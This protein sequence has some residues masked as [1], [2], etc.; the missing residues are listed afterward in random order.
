MSDPTT[1][2]AAGSRVDGQPGEAS[3]WNDDLDPHLRPDLARSALLTIDVQVD[4]L[5]GGAL[6]VPGTSE[7]LPAMAGLV[8]AYRAAGLPVVHV[9]RL[10]QGEDVDLPRRTAIAAGAEI[11]RPGT[12]G[13]QLAPALRADPGVELDHDLLLSGGPQMVGAREAILFKPRWSAFYRTRLAELLQQW[14]CT[15]VVVAGCNYPNCPRASLYDASERDYRALLASDA[16]SGIDHRH[17]REA[18]AIGVVHAES[19]AIISRLRGC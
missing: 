15:T 11:V 4:F 17:L 14:G 19:G 18:A 6:P 5:D 3:N 1:A 8:G 2:S 16:V 13:A 10:Y 9:V 12:E 7:V